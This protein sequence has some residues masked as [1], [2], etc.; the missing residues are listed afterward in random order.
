MSNWQQKRIKLQQQK[1]MQSAASVAAAAADGSGAVESGIACSG[2]KWQRASLLEEEVARHAVRVHWHWH[3][4][5]FSILSR[6]TKLFRLNHG[7]YEK[8]R[9][10]AAMSCG[11]NVGGD[12][13]QRVG[14]GAV[15]IPK[16]D[17]NKL[18]YCVLSRYHLVLGHS[19]QMTQGEQAFDVLRAWFNVWFECFTSLLN[20]TCGT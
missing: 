5:D 8:L 17:F 3:S 13:N 4:V 9:L 15:R 16:L 12:P 19:F 7:H 11:S 20:C 6:S 10:L 2:Q 18:V 14:T 1:V